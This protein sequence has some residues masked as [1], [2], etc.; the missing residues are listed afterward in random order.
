MVI[1][2]FKKYLLHDTLSIVFIQDAIMTKVDKT[3]VLTV[4]GCREPEA[5]KQAI[6]FGWE[7]FCRRKNRY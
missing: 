6:D 5:C 1:D 2:P 4:K 7:W 3:A